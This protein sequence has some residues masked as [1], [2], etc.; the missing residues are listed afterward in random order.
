MLHVVVENF[1]KSLSEREF[2]APLL[3]ILASQGFY[4]IHFIHG[5][6]EFG[7]DVIAKKLNPETGEARQYAIQSKAGD[8]NLASWREVRP[9]IEEC[10]YNTRSHPAFDT[11]LSR[12]AVLATTGRLKGGAAVDAQEFRGQC[13]SRGLA[14][15]EVWDQQTILDWLCQDPSLGLTP[16]NAQDELIT[17]VSKI[18]GGFVTEPDLEHFTRSWLDAVACPESQRRASIETSIL[19]N[20]LRSVQRL[21]L[22]AF[23]SLHLLRACWTT[24]GS[25]ST[26]Q[27]PPE[28]RSAIRLFS[29]Y[30]QEILDQVEELLKDSVAFAR[31]I[32][33]PNAIATY[34][35]ACCRLGEL[36]GLLALVTTDDELRDRAGNAVVTLCSTHPGSARPPADLFAEAL[37]PMVVALA[38]ANRG[39]VAGYLRS[40]S[41]WLLDRHD[42]K[43][44]GLGLASLD[45]D[46]ET[47]V[48]RLLGG[49]LDSTQLEPRKSSYSATVLLD[50]LITMNL[51]ELY[52]AVRE[53]LAAL[54][55]APLITVA[56]E[57]KAAWRRGGADIFPHPSIQYLPWTEARPAHHKRLAPLPPTDTLLLSAVCRSRH[58]PTA[59]SSLVGS[60]EPFGD[61]SQLP[62]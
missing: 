1:L 49:A 30:A 6:F 48:E 42:P 15:F 29:Y 4:D 12:V 35:V 2:D 25:D 31:A 43:H 22:A 46:E 13:Q 9:Q 8:I 53:N 41:M 33:T 18:R 57:S 54:Q 21:D 38:R 17:I 34:P 11:S 26:R 61:R 32:V 10:E 60:A 55:I 28:Y 27:P 58:Y 7:K 47:A 40:V 50:L 39:L 5:G 59:I 14:D 52:E 44:D 56:D 19:C 3:A 24:H 36:F 37:I 20:S 16:S 62:N 23:T 45:E 51:E